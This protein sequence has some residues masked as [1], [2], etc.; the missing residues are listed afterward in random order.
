MITPVIPAPSPVRSWFPD[1]PDPADFPASEI[2]DPAVPTAV[3]DHRP[4]VPALSEC[5]GG[6]GYPPFWQRLPWRR[7]RNRSAAA[8]PRMLCLRSGIL[9]DL[10]LQFFRK[11]DLPHV[12]YRSLLT[13]SDTF[14]Q[15]YVIL[16]ALLCLGLPLHH[17]F[18][19]CIVV[20]C[21]HIC[22][23]TAPKHHSNMVSPFCELSKP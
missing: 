1:C 20:A 2:K 5:P 10:L 18:Y 22:L 6:S 8:C 11:V 23:L 4:A 14:C 15:K 17:L 3:S 19:F 12:F 7:S 9:P 16:A 21:D 13:H